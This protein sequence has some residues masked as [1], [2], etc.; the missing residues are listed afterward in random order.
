M[1]ADIF[2][3]WVSFNPD[4]PL[5]LILMC[6][7]DGV[8][9]QAEKR[10][11]KGMEVFHFV[12]VGL[13]CKKLLGLWGVSVLSARLKRE[14]I[15]VV[16]LKQQ[17]SQCL[18]IILMGWEK[19]RTQAPPPA[20]HVLPNPLPVNLPQKRFELCFYNTS[21]I[22]D[23]LCITSS[24]IASDLYPESKQCLQSWR[25]YWSFQVSVCSRSDSAQCIRKRRV[26]FLFLWL[27]GFLVPNVVLFFIFRLG[28]V[29]AKCV[30]SCLLFVFQV[31]C[32]GLLLGPRSWRKTQVSAA[33]AMFNWI[34]CSIGSLRLK[35]RGKRFN[36]LTG[37]KAWH[38][39]AAP[40]ITRTRTRDVYKATLKGESTSSKT[41]CLRM[42]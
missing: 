19:A 39:F 11:L 3:C 22:S 31:C 25:V 38:T 18:I 42:L 26:P 21:A 27:P 14:A 30:F 7:W 32:D 33:G 13:W 34:P 6:E 15:C 35:L 12:F 9:H 10:E 23:E 37:K 4:P 5:F 8:N 40:C 1:Q 2:C 29:V 17:H 24:W 28:T 41:L 36:S 16:T 20:S